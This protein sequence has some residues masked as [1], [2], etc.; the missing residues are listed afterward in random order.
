MKQ[1]KTIKYKKKRRK[2]NLVDWLIYIFM[3]LFAVLVIYPFWDIFLTSFSNPISTTSLGLH[4]WMKEWQLD[5]YV[6]VL[7]DIKVLYAYGNT[8]FRTFV[9]TSLAVLTTLLC[10]YPLS[11]KKLPGRNVIT[12]YFL[13]V[14]FFNGGLIPTYLLIKNLDLIDKRFV[15]ILP[16]LLNVYYMI[17]MR[18]YLMSMDD[19]LE[20][21]AFIDGA[22]YI[23]ILFKI[24]VPLAKPVI[25]TVVLWIAVWHWNSWF[26]ALIYIRDEKKIVLQTLLRRMLQYASAESNAL[27]DFN[28]EASAKIVSNTVRAAVTMITIG[29]IILLYPSLQKYFI[30]GIMV[31]SFKRIARKDIMFDYKKAKEAALERSRRIMYDN[32]GCDVTYYCDDSTD[33]DILRPMMMPLAGTQVDSVTCATMS[34]GFGQFTHLTKLGSM[35]ATKEGTYFNNKTADLAERGTDHLRIKIDFC[36]RH[37]LEVFWQMR[38]NDTHDGAD[39]T[40]Y[41]PVIYKN[42]RIKREHPEYMVAKPHAQTKCGYWSAVDY[43]LDEVRG[44]AYGFVEEILDNYDVDGINLD[45]F[46]HPVFFKST[47]RGEKTTPGE[48]EMM[49]ELMRS[50]ARMMEE[51][52]RAREKALLLAVRVP[53][54]VEYCRAIG[55]DIEKWLEEGLVDILITTSYIHLNDWDYSVKLARKYG[56]KIYPSLDEARIKDKEGRA[57]RERLECYRARAMNAWHADVDGIYLFNYKS[58]DVRAFGPNSEDIFDEIGSPETLKGKNKTYYASYRGLGEIAGGG[59]PHK[60]YVN[61]PVLN[62]KKPIEVSLASPCSINIMMGEDMAEEA[63]PAIVLSARVDEEI[64]TSCVLSSLNGHELEYAGSDGHWLMYEV[65]KEALIRGINEFAMVLRN[66][67]K[68]FSLLDLKID[69]KYK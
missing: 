41:G 4:L 32:D 39:Q 20:E 56:V 9:G 27:E 22:G 33:E 40:P 61:I 1:T 36:R 16:N 64:D 42:N 60:E 46:R 7:S 17:I 51:K 34:S 6:F 29:P 38:M 2:L 65:K 50:I 63:T 62:P 12:L 24:V 11:K 19:A 13:F 35:Y 66:G 37:G 5:S 44:L 47:S 67:G 28:Q 43:A 48:A 59:Y 8:I 10:A 45:F 55:L 54:S 21:S 69:I 68:P 25:A 14:M 52:G 3:A 23:T 15:L 58:R 49:T 31:G 30:K 26:D 53:D 18:N 57:I